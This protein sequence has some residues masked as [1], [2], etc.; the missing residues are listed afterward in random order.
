M[1][2]IP[3][4]FEQFLDGD[5][6]DYPTELKELLASNPPDFWGTSVLRKIGHKK[7]PTL[8]VIRAT[9]MDCCHNHRSSVRF[10]PIVQCPSWPYMLA[11]DPFRKGRGGDDA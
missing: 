8:R 3:P 9:C 5:L 6:E 7:K 1:S 2:K 4:K 11:T 10:C